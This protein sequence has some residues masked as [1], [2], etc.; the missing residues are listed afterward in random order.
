M[1]KVLILHWD[2]DTT[3]EA[4]VLKSIDILVSHD[5]VFS[6]ACC[7]LERERGLYQCVWCSFTVTESLTLTSHS[8]FS[9]CLDHLSGTFSTLSFLYLNHNLVVNF[10]LKREVNKFYTKFC[11]LWE[12]ISAS[13]GVPICTLWL[14]KGTLNI[15]LNSLKVKWQCCEHLFIRE[16]E[17]QCTEPGR[18]YQVCCPSLPFHPQ[19][20]SAVV[21]RVNM[22]RFM[23]LFTVHSIMPS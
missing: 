2:V 20:Y 3:K 6:L 16:V 17:W 22:T 23:E 1:T 8:F 18:Q 12:T 7:L 11:G 9:V 5:E 13:T 4:L 15:Y 19:E 21:T 10:I 14:L